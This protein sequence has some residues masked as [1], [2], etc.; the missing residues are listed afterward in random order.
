VATV[1]TLPDA[2]ELAAALARYG[3]SADAATA[4]SRKPKKPVW[5]VAAPDGEAYLKRLPYRRARVV[6]S[7]AAG[8]H[9][10]AQGAGVP[11]LLRTLDAEVCATV[12]RG[13]YVLCAAVPARAPTYARDLGAIA[14]ALARFH[15]RSPGFAPP[16]GSAPRDH[17]DAWPADYRQGRARLRAAEAL[18]AGG[19]PLGASLLAC[20]AEVQGMAREAAERLAAAFPAAAA[21]AAARPRLCH[22]D[23]SA[24]NLR[25]DAAAAVVAFDIDS[26]AYDLP[27]RDL[28]KLLNKVMKEEGAWSAERAGAALAAYSAVRPLSGEERALLLADLRFPHLVSGLV[29]KLFLKPAAEWPPEDCSRRLDQVIA[30][31]RSKV[32]V[33]Q[34][35]A[36]QWGL[37]A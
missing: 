11:R 23:F 33:L 5:R 36:G 31:E 24:S 8:D 20:A 15:E 10:H 26:V 35:L 22:Q 2:A 14:A 16:P 12:G 37:P 18:A 30:V 25:I 34:R 9:L 6:F 1:Y 21:A 19:H 32:A 27:V 28:R 4:V 13:C 29:K 3:L 7:A 17:L